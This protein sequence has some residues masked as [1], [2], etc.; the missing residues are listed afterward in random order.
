M[1]LIVMRL[2]LSFQMSMLI[3]TLA[4]RVYATIH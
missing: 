3:Y 2:Y 4:Y 1:S